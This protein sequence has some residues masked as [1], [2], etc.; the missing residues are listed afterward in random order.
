[1]LFPAGSPAQAHC[2]A[3]RNPEGEH[4][5]VRLDG[6]D[7]GAARASCVPAMKL[8]NVNAR[9]FTALSLKSYMREL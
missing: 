7:W 3:K 4:F 1:M 2:A 6:L 9:S 5:Q 8:L